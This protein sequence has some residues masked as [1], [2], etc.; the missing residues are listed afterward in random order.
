MYLGIDP[1][2]TI[3]YAKVVVE[4]SRLVSIMVSQERRE[5]WSSFGSK[6]LNLVNDCDVLVIED[7]VGSGHR[8][9]ESN[10]V[11][12]MIG[13]FQLA[14]LAK[15]KIVLVQAPASRRKYLKT[16]E[17]LY[18]QH[19]GYPICHHGRDALA[20][21]LKALAGEGLNPKGWVD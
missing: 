8:S 18:K 1:G 3:G 9:K 20:H 21:V 6:P 14:G 12:K 7:F 19:T 11:L 13:A 15:G 17:K 4:G 16:S 2:K 10:L 5:D